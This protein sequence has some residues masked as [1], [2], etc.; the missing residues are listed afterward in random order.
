MINELKF[1]ASAKGSLVVG[2]SKIAKAVGSTL[3]PKGQCVILDNY[4]NGLPH[5]TK[6][7]VTVAKNIFLEDKYENVGATLLKQA[8]LNTVNS[9][10][11]ATTT[12]TVLANAMVQNAYAT[13]M[14][15]IK[16]LSLLKKGIK[17]AAEHVNQVIIDSAASVTE[18][19]FEKI[20][21]I[22]A[23][24]DSE[25]GKIVAEAFDKVGPDGV[26][27]VE[28]SANNQTTVEVITGMQFERGFMSHWFITDRE[29]GECVLESPIIL[30]TDQKINLTREILPIAEYCVKNK[31][32]LLIIAQDFDD[33]V[34]Q[35]MR[36]NHL[37]GILRCCLVKAPSFGDYRK[38][39][40]EDLAILTNAKLATY[41]N[42]IEVS[43]IDPS[44]LGTCGKVVINKTHT[45]ILNGS[46]DV[47]DRVAQLKTELSQL[48]S[49]EET[50]QKFLKQRIAH[51]SGGIGVIK[52]GGTSELEMREK[53]DRI[54]DAVCATQA[55]YQEG[56]VPGGGL[57]FLKAYL[58]MPSSENAAIQQGI[59]VVSK[60]LTCIFDTIVY[61]A[62]YDP[63]VIGK[64]VFPDKNVSWNADTEEY[65]DFVEAGIINPTKADRLAFEN[66]V[67]VLN[68]FVS[69]NCIIIEKDVFKQL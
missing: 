17:I 1:D 62:G 56:V 66:A 42:G 54:D 55:A 63:K 22:S 60:A 48:Q 21:T 5:V 31:K 2:M 32:A 20:A 52:V 4:S 12:S 39:L 24:N 3:G 50:M 57:T 15:G 36:I 59:D 7:G 46:G 23:N 41:D 35:N 10:G 30:L 26:L 68:M 29:K 45:T 65:V 34:V 61:N 47:S 28:E 25:I 18:S 11:D 53:K 40:L 16:N 19:E 38:K 37:Q 67:G 51:L 58:S 6:D 9:V 14:S 27:T 44:M 13:Y 33:E 43:K 69:T 64:E 8:A 49:G